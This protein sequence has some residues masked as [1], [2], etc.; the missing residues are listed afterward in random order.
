MEVVGLVFEAEVRARV[1][2]G[3]RE[4]GKVWLCR[5]VRE[6][7]GRIGSDRPD[8][9]VVEPRDADGKST[10]S[11]VS[12]LRRELPSV[13]VI[14]CCSLSANAGREILLF[15]R[16]GAGH[17]ILLGHDGFSTSLRPVL[18]RGG[19]RC[20]DRVGSVPARGGF[21][22]SSMLIVADRH[23]D[24][25]APLPAE[26]LLAGGQVVAFHHRSGRQSGMALIDGFRKSRLVR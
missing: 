24:A 20:A 15:G 19:G 25:I 13:P 7:I 12:L 22:N 8:A 4:Y 26:C 18:E 14:V 23:R 6:L 5:R 17:V 9:I 11:T 16:A 21:A 3:V 1:A 2:A 10:V